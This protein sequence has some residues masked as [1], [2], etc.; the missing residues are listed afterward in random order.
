MGWRVGDALG[1]ATTKHSSGHRCTITGIGMGGEWQLTPSAILSSSEHNHWSRADLAFDSDDLTAWTSANVHASGEA[2]TGEWLYAKLP[3]PSVLTRVQILWEAPP[4]E[5]QV[6]IR[7]R[8]DEE[9]EPP[10][11]DGDGALAETAAGCA[12]R[13]LRNTTTRIAPPRPPPRWHRR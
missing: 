7:N 8:T 5:Y 4:L 12:W 6:L 2:I 11:A 13:A 1:I 10:T 3:A 9:C